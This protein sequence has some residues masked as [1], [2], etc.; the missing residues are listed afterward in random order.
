MESF[1]RNRH[2][3]RPPGSLCLFAQ[4]LPLFEVYPAPSQIHN[5][6]ALKDELENNSFE[7]LSQITRVP[8]PVFLWDRHAKS[9]AKLTF[10]WQAVAPNQI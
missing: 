9:L 3:K 1:I 4:T 6:L 7:M 8:E 2:A 10:C 5:L